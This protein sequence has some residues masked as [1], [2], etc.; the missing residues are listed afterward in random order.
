M[1]SADATAAVDHQN[2]HQKQQQPSVSVPAAVVLSGTCSTNGG[3]SKLVTSGGA[4]LSHMVRPKK[5]AKNKNKTEQPVAQQSQENSRKDAINKERA[6]A[7]AHASPPPSSSSS[8]S[9][10]AAAAPHRSPA[11][12]SSSAGV[13]SNTAAAAAVAAALAKAS[14]ESLLPAGPCYKHSTCTDAG[15]CASDLKCHDRA[16]CKHGSVA[17]SVRAIDGLC[18]ELN[19][20]AAAAAA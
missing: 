15:F 19:K 1:R 14:P 7:H 8:S 2:H 17:D 11:A 10:E 12:P 5:V 18:P 20:A 6:T 3:A 9:A 16:G 13:P 4:D